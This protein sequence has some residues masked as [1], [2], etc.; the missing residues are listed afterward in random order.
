MNLIVVSSVFAAM[1]LWTLPAASATSDDKLKGTSP[2]TLVYIAK[3]SP[4]ACGPGC[5]RWIAVEGKIDE[6]AAARLRKVLLSRQAKGLPIYLHSPG[7]HARQSLAMGRMLR[8]RKATA[9]VARTMVKE[10]GG[11]QASADCVKLKQGGKELEATLT[12]AQAH[13]S[14]GCTFVLIGAVTRE[15]A[16]GVRFAVHSAGITLNDRL[17]RVPKATRDRAIGR[18]LESLNRDIAA[19]LVAMGID[20]GLFELIKTVRF[21]SL[22]ALSRDE[23]FRFGID[24]REYVET[25]WTFTGSWIEKLVQARGASDAND[26]RTRRWRLVCGTE[27]D[28]LLSYARN[29]RDE[30][31]ASAVLRLGADQKIAFGALGRADMRIVMVDAGMIGKLKAAAQL[32]LMEVGTVDTAKGGEPPVR[33]TILS[34]TGLSRSIEQ[35]SSSCSVFSRRG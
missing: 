35:L 8:E 28:M 24:R 7:G 17:R 31:L 2:V 3:G 27:R 16:F 6:A 34:T 1:A 14:S 21:E 10:C 30:P 32:S 15:V 5:D 25:D 19:Y 23:L 4:D 20:R 26:F 11:D 12:T 18:G 9:R 33:E 13:C 22:H 29:N